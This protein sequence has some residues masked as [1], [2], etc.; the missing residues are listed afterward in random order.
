MSLEQLLA[1]P[2]IWRGRAGVPVDTVATGWPSLDAVLPGG[3]WPRGALIE[4]FIGA[5]GIGEIGLLLPALAQLSAEGQPQAWIAPPLLPYAPA[6]AA[7]GLDLSRL[8]IVQP[9]QAT[10][11]AWAIEECLRADGC[12]AVVAWPPLLDGRSLRRLQLA[13]AAS[14]ACGF[15][16]S[17]PGARRQPSPAALRIGVAP[18]PGQALDITVFKARG[19]RPQ[20]V[21]VQ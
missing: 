8:L 15:L 19:M 12:G 3:G 7:A 9:P 11:V 13:A 4:V 1:V 18:G 6:L 2:G 17:P 10:R 21:T 20:R 14:G 5:Q 16:F